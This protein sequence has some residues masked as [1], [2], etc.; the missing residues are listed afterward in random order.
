MNVTRS[1]IGI[2]MLTIVAAGCST[3]HQQ[4]GSVDTK[5]YTPPTSIYNILD[6]TALVYS[7]PAAGSAVNDHPLRWLGFVSNPIGHAFDYAINRP[8]YSLA[9]G[10]AYLSGYTAEDNMVNAQRR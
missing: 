7:D 3:M 9:S 10:F 2:V 1:V 4:G 5:E 6:S 8:I